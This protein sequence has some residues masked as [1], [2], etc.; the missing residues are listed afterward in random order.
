[1]KHCH[2]GAR[3]RAGPIFFSERPVMSAASDLSHRLA[4][5]AEAVCRHYLSAGRRE[6]RYW[7]VGDAMG[8]AGR[9]L[10]VRL[11]GPDHGRGAAGKWTDA[12]TGAHGDLLDLLALNCGHCRL[13]D[14][15]DEARRFLALPVTE[16]PEIVDDAPVLT[17]S[18]QA[19][20]RLFAA[21]HP[22]GATLAERYLFSRRITGV[23]T[24]P[25]L[26]FHGACWYRPD[27]DDVAPTPAAMPALISA[28]TDVDGAIMGVHRTWLDSSGC[29]KAPVAVPRRAMGELLGHG[30]RFGAAGP[31]MVAGEGIETVLSLRMAMPR[32]PMI[33]ALSAAHLAAI[34]FPPPL[35][36]L[37]VAREED[38]AGRA[39]FGA[40]ETR[41]TAAGIE[42]LPLESV[43]DDF[44]ADLCASG[45]AK[46]AEWLRPQ[47][48]TEDYAPFL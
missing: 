9:S 34:R 23:R 26:R 30:V 18:P 1:M 5:N 3:H 46:L 15:L 37:Y 16:V 41:A 31:V 45:T 8:S 48:R 39:A 13:P 40:L 47:L 12:A 20:R 22:I 7:I 29:G 28:V 33:A 35:R 25:W 44:N 21:S 2:L 14:T 27:R 43:L 24:E 11:K 32:L 42:L 4:R 36:R 10:Y 6:G 19:A 17:G 38:G